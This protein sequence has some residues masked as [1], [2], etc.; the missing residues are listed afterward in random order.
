MGVVGRSPR[1]SI[2]LKF[3][4]EQIETIVEKIDVQI[5]RTGILTPVAHVSPVLVNGVMITRASLHN[6]EE[7]ERKD[8]CEGDT[9]ILKRAG[10]VIP[11]IVSVKKEHRPT[12][13]KKFTLPTT[14]PLCGSEII[15][16]PQIVAR[17]CSGEFTCSGQ[18]VERLKHFVSRDA[19]DIRGLGEKQLYQFFHWGIARRPSDL[20]LIESINK[21]IIP[22]LQA[23]EGWG[24][25][26]VNNLFYAINNRRSISMERFIYALG[27]PQVGRTLA[28]ILSLSFQGIDH[29]MRASLKDLCNIEGV[30]IQIAEDV[31]SFFNKHQYYQEVEKLLQH[32]TIEE[33]S[34]I[35]SFS[36]TL[37]F[38][39]K[40][41]TLSRAEAKKLAE[42]HGFLVQTEVCKTT[43]LIVVGEK[44]G[45]KLKQGLTFSIPTIMEKEWLETLMIGEKSKQ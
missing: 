28:H 14:C 45:R 22:P 27:I 6:Q 9:V 8:I 42:C 30:G 44:P 43:K 16:L 23:R 3:E 25:K 7:I 15:S 35:R 38:T 31:I 37:V 5:G 40:L 10:D 20:F 34:S 39:G 13:A 1:H 19:F 33:R 24:L 26:A 4:A 32:V 36:N 2:A 12:T 21:D 11:Q 41:L 17:K 18:I 29:L